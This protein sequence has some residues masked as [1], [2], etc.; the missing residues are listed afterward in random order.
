MIGS[1]MG[2]VDFTNPQ[3]NPDGTVLSPAFGWDEASG[4]YVP[5]NTLYEKQGYWAAVLGACDLTVGGAGGS[6]KVGVPEFVSYQWDGFV[7]RFGE[8]PPP[9]P[10]IDVETG[11]PRAISKEYSLSQ[12]YPNPF[13]STT[14]IM[15]Q[16]P[17]VGDVKLSI[18]NPMGQEV[19]TLVED[20]KQAGYHE[21]FWDGKDDAGKEAGSGVYIVR[22]ESNRF[23]SSKKIVFLR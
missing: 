10:D 23:V 19:R 4:L 20:T 1:V 12:N 7:K 5:A 11:R 18:Y 14:K 22:I 9:P 17:G 3:D 15:Y 13:N 16:L 8:V 6:K 21:I 2:S